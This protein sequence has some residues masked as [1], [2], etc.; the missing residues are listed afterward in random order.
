MKKYLLLT[1][2]FTGC[3]SSATFAQTPY[4]LCSNEQ[5]QKLIQQFNLHSTGNKTNP[6]EGFISCLN[7]NPK[8]KTQLL[9]ISRPIHPLD[10]NGDGNFDLKL[11]WVDAIKNKILQSYQSPEIIVSD[12]DYYENLYFDVNAFSTLAQTHVVGLKV[13][14]SHRGGFSYS[15]DSLS[16]FKVGTSGIQNVLSGLRTQESGYETIGPCLADNAQSDVKRILVLGQ[17]THFGLQ[18]IV[19][20]ETKDQTLTDYRTCRTTQKQDQQ[21]QTLK[22]NGQTYQFESH[23]L[24]QRDAF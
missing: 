16:L 10:E 5:Q 2:S 11:Y 19:L 22:F 8:H 9:A 13:R 20:K 14:H 17:K 7:L 18:D 15:D 12:A 6:S 23:D 4:S 1:L 3:L 21:Q 24:L